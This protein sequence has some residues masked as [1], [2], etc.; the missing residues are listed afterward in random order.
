MSWYNI[1]QYRSFN[2]AVDRFSNVLFRPALDTPVVSTR[3]ASERVIYTLLGHRHVLAYLLAI[4]SFLRFTT[5]LEFEVVVQSDGSLNDSDCE[6]LRRHVK[7]IVI[8]TREE[9][10][11]FLREATPPHA[12]SPVLTN[13]CVLLPLKLLNVFHR[14]RERYVILFDSDLLFLRSPVEVIECLKCEGNKQVFHPPGGSHL[15]SPFRKIGFPFPNVSISEFNSGFVGFR[16]SFP[17]EL[18]DET[19]AKIANYDQGLFRQWEIEQAIWCVLLNYCEQPINLGRLAKGYVGN[20][21][22]SYEE[23]SRRAILVHFVGSTRFRNLN[24]PRLAR[25]VAGELQAGR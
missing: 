12:N 25:H 3:P 7:K 17:D 13:P 1:T 4:K 2:R 24:Y 20:G 11:E 22:R 14:F 21:W 6:L 23:L 18:L 15:S 16:N 10:N 5:D 8:Y 9:C 19:L